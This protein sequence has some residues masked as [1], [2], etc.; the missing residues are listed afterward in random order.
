MSPDCASEVMPVIVITPPASL[1]TRD[2]GSVVPDPPPVLSADPLI[3]KTPSCV[4]WSAAVPVPPSALSVPR[5]PC[6]K[7]S[8]AALIPSFVSALCTAD[9]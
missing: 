3:S 2:A 9:I 8:F 6:A 7:T 1:I 4:I 5:L